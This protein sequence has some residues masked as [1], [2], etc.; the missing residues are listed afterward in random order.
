[1]GH[2]PLDDLKP[3][4]PEIYQAAK[5]LLG[6]TSAGNDARAFERSTLAPL[7]TPGMAIYD[8]LRGGVFAA[9]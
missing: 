3:A 4:G 2:D 8:E 9:A 5:R 1:M 7:I 6:L